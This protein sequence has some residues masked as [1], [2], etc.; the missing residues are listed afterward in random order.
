MFFGGVI[1]LS[2]TLGGIWHNLQTIW[3]L[4]L[5]LVGF[6]ARISGMVVDYKAEL[7]P[8]TTQC[9]AIIT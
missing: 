1:K 9:T 2:L 4:T 7:L 6:S 8:A 3:I 5:G